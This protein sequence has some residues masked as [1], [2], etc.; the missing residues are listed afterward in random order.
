MNKSTKLLATLAVFVVAFAGVSIFASDDA[1]ATG[2]TCP[3]SGAVAKI[4]DTEYDTLVAAVAAAEKAGDPSTTI[5]VLRCS[6]GEGIFI[7]GGVGFTID[8][9]SH[10]YTCT[11]PAVGSSGTESQAIHIDT[12][13]GT[14]VLKNGTITSVEGSGVKM[15][16]QVH[17]C[18]LTIED[19]TLDGSKLDESNVG[20]YTLST[21][22]LANIVIKGKTT[23]VAHD[24]PGA[25]A[26]DVYGDSNVT[27]EDGTFEGMIEFTDGTFAVEGGTFSD[28]SVI[29]YATKGATIN[30]VLDA[31]Q[32][33]P[34]IG[35]FAKSKGQTGVTLNI[36]LAGFT[37]TCVGPA[38]G[39]STTQS[40]V[41]HFEKDNTVSISNGKI[42]SVKDPKILMLIQNYCDLTLEKVTV[43]AK[44]TD[45]VYPVSNNC[46]NVVITDSKIISKDGKFGLF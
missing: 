13:A 29:N 23:I 42:T 18:D 30:V 39:S 4:G 5:N 32:T 31:D 37:Y 12:G 28:M 35:L 40:Q 33:G 44:G 1:S 14:I 3:D 46:G 6:E 24:S 43:D 8:F 38:V 22:K 9:N 25:Y 34:G 19:M 7:H 26:F 17:K 11:G 20:Y 41:F 2:H 15:L 36:D 10:K 16:V 21:Y 27:V 45:V